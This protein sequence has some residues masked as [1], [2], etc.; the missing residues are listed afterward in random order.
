M[1]AFLLLADAANSDTS[2]SKVNMLGAGWSITGPAPQAAAITGFLRV[3][4]DE[5]RDDISFTLRLFDGAG[6]SVRPFADNDRPLHF[7]GTF[8]L[9]DDEPAD[10]TAKQIPLNFAFSIAIPPLPLQPGGVYRWVLE[11]QGA[12]VAW[13]AFAVRPEKP[14]P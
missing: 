13:V 9:P 10:S 8:T 14:A 12:D 7:K 2:S 6:E 4:W 11:A 1:E 3:A 5:A